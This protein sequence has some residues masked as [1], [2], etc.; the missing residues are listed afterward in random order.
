MEEEDF[1]QLLSDSALQI[2][3]LSCYEFVGFIYRHLWICHFVQSDKDCMSVLEGMDVGFVWLLYWHYFVFRVKGQFYIPA[4]C[5]FS[6][7]C[8]VLLQCF[9]A[10]EIWFVFVL[11]VFCCFMGF[12]WFGCFSLGG[13]LFVCCCFPA[14][15]L[16]AFITHFCLMT[17]LHTCVQHF[18]QVKQ[19]GGEKCVKLH[20]N[21][22]CLLSYS[23]K[24]C[25]GAGLQA[26]FLKGAKSLLR[27]F[28]LCL[29]G[30]K[31]HP[32]KCMYGQQILP[33]W[34]LISSDVLPAC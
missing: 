24:F 3:V 15:K 11:F 12:C 20:T 32:S 13:C 1:Q 8:S 26:F 19:N 9:H 17:L 34:A 14:V 33:A 27:W 18:V 21:N 4:I 30:Q 6:T 5:R 2:R 10:K 25:S 16:P 29:D 23:V 7:R 31:V 28:C 22:M